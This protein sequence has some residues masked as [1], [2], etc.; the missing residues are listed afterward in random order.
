MNVIPFST[1]VYRY[2]FFGWL[3]QDLERAGGDVFQRA[4]IVRR[5]TKSL[6]AQPGGLLRIA[7]QQ[8]GLGGP[9][10]HIR[11]AAMARDHGLES[12]QRLPVTIHHAQRV[13]RAGGGVP[14]ARIARL[15]SGIDGMRFLEPSFVGQEKGLIHQNLAALR[16]AVIGFQELVLA[17]QL[18]EQGVEIVMERGIGATGDSGWDLMSYLAFQPGYVG[19]LL[20]LGYEDT[21]A[22]RAEIEAFFEAPA[23]GVSASAFAAPAVRG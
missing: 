7:A 23:D 13:G 6:V 18:E 2:F 17:A 4:A 9:A 11:I 16:H 22:R 5:Q 14:V 21:L 20:E 1:L 19:K 15:Q 10:I 8:R 12:G 3:F